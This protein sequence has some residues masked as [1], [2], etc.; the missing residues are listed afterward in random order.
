MSS[1]TLD[2]VERVARTVVQA[3]IAAVLAVIVGSGGWDAIDWNVVWKV[4][5]FAGI[6]ALLTALAAKGV[7]SSADA[8]FVSKPE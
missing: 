6:I 8:S 2:A 7:G 4:G 5:A 1:F 3:V